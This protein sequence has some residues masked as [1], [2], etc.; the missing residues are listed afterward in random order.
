VRRAHR[1]DL[2]AG[3]ATLPAGSARMS[4]RALRAAAMR[5][6]PLA[7]RTYTSSMEGSIDVVR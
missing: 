7:G 5:L 1:A 3:S 6:I 2:V 4:H